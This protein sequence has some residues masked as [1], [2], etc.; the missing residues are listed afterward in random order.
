MSYR[1]L[2]NLIAIFIFIVF[3]E[4]LFDVTVHGKYHDSR[5]RFTFV[6]VNVRYNLFGSMGNELSRVDCQPSRKRHSPRPPPPPPFLASD[7]CP[8]FVRVQATVPATLTQ[9]YLFMPQQMKTCFVVQVCFSRCGAA[10][11]YRWG[12]N[13]YRA[14]VGC[15]V[16]YAEKNVPGINA[17]LRRS[18][19]PPV[20]ICW[21]LY[22]TYPLAC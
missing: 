14:A 15:I 10:T 21:W 19:T 5:K 16:H 4:S 22:G 20:Y 9:E 6:V 13:P 3:C 12:N 18:L 7:S 2:R 8:C 11:R 1:C 17:S